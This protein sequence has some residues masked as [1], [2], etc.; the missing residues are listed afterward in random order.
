MEKMIVIFSII[1]GIPYAY[2]VSRYFIES[3][4]VCIILLFL[5]SNAIITEEEKQH[6]IYT[7]YMDFCK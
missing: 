1:H 4:D 7:E 5:R 3:K 2:H 6:F